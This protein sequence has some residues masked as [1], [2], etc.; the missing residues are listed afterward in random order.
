MKE[1]KDAYAKMVKEEVIRTEIPVKDWNKCDVCGG[2]IVTRCR[3]MGPH[4]IESLRKGHGRRCENGHLLGDG[5][6]LDKEGNE[7]KI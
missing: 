1:I 5:V 4:T 2:K 6:Y 7:G 3:C